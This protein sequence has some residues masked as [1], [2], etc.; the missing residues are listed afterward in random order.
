MRTLVA[1][2]IMSLLL[3][4]SV[5][6]AGPLTVGQLMARCGQLDVSEHNQVKLRSGSVGAALDAGKCWGHLEAYLDLSTIELPGPRRHVLGACPPSEQLN[7][8]QM[9]EMFLEHARNNPS[10]LQKPAALIVAN[11]LAQKFPCRG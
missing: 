3:G 10:E 11:L 1:A 2:W 5:N 6:A 7:F 4:T 8:T 9:I